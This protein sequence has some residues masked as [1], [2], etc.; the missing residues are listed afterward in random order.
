MALFKSSCG[1]RMYTV[2]K[3]IISILYNIYIWYNIYYIIYIIYYIIYGTAKIANPQMPWTN[4]SIVGNNP[5]RT[6]GIIWV[7]S[8]SDF[9]SICP[10][11]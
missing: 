10:Q 5:K 3:C 8:A 1:I 9:G 2:Y 4:D 11:I 7:Y 6:F